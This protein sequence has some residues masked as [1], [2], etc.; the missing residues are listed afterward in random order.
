M[1]Q[2]TPSASVMRYA[3]IIAMSPTRQGRATVVVFVMRESPRSLS[4]DSH[5]I[6]AALVTRKAL[7]DERPVPL[8]I[9]LTFRAQKPEAILRRLPNHHSIQRL[10]STCPRNY[11]ILHFREGW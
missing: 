4:E 6:P 5:Q 7:G 2:E 8:L 11:S 3:R 1:I 10:H 9:V